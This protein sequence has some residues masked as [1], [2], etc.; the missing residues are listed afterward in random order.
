MATYEQP[1]GEAPAPE[2]LARVQDFINT[3]DIEG[4]RETLTSSSALAAWFRGQ[5]LLSGR[6]RIDDGDVERAIAIREALREACVANHDRATID[7]D[8]AD[9]LNQTAE[10]ASYRIEFTGDG[11][12]LTPTVGGSTGALGQIV[13]DVFAARTDGTWQRLKACANHGCRWVF[14]DHSRSRTK[15][16]CSMAICGNRQ[17]VTD[18]Y[19]R[20]N[21][22]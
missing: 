10:G 9:L 18:Y 17:K 11:D 22:S 3:W 6:S 21:V 8:V 5:G 14:Y 2:R 4:E 7:E 16:W 13:A 12:H 1:G 19:H 20:H 15:R